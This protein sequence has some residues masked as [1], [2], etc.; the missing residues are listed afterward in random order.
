MAGEASEKPSEAKIKPA[1]GKSKRKALKEKLAQREAEET[2]PKTAEELLAQKLEQQRLVEESDL[3]LAKD[4]F[5]V[6]TGSDASILDNIRLASKEDFEEFRKALEQ[7]LSPFVRSP[8][9]A[10]FLEDLFRNL[11]TSLDTEDIKKINHALNSL[12]NEKIKLQKVCFFF[13]YLWLLLNLTCLLRNSNKQRARRRT[14]RTS[15]F[16]WNVIA[17]TITTN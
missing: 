17:I 16:E 10:S 2:R 8:Y 11:S 9:Y 12:Y 15:S 7:K 13:V 6:S 1:Q 3:D 5:G 14:K 4:T